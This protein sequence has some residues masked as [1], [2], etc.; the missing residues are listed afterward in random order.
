MIGL[1]EK[2]FLLILPL[3]IAIIFL[4]M[5]LFYGVRIIRDF[6]KNFDKEKTTNNATITL[7]IRLRAYERLTL[8]MDRID[9]K[10]LIPRS[11]SP[12]QNALEFKDKLIQNIR[13][14]YQH[15]ASQQIYVSE[16]LWEEMKDA[17]LN[18]NQLI[19]ASYGKC[20]SNTPSELLAQIILEA[21]YSQ[22]QSFIDLA[23]LSI[24][25]EVK[26]LL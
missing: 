1:N 14:E 18:L 5:L 12:T 25:S 11:I 13:E 15:N 10:N 26:D 8:L 2:F 20:D 19:I 6:K 24:K 17:Q 22:E 16:I 23:Q 21:Y 4:A 9:P 3:F 7:P